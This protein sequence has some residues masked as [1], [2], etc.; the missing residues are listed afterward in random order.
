[1]SAARRGVDV[2][3]TAAATNHPNE[4]ASAVHAAD[5]DAVVTAVQ[6]DT[7]LTR[8]LGVV[9]A[10]EP[11]PGFCGSR[12]RSL[13]DRQIGESLIDARHIDDLALVGGVDLRFFREHAIEAARRLRKPIASTDQRAPEKSVARGG[14]RRRQGGDRLVD[15]G[16]GEATAQ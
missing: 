6:V 7:Q 3:V 12:L 2:D 1:M 5:D 10:A 9:A 11:G 14:K 8:L 13:V 15:H 16:V 4:R